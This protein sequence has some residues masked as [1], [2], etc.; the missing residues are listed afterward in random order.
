ML[1]V[2]IA[3]LVAITLTI[4]VIATPFKLIAL[5]IPIIATPLKRGA[6]KAIRGCIASSTS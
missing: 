6:Y 4:P 2:S 1:V 5:I 3:K